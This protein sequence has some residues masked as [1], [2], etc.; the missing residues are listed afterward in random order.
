MFMAEVFQRGF[1][2]LE[3]KLINFTYYP[4]CILLCKLQ[5]HGQGF[6]RRGLINSWC[7]MILQQGVKILTLIVIDQWIFPII[8]VIIQLK[9][10]LCV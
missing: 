5:V 2:K 3:Q 6:S 4:W 1:E 8:I 7:D 10:W 9:S